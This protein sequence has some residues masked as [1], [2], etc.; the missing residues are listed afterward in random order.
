M[1]DYIVVP[2]KIDI[3]VACPFAYNVN[4]AP[5]AIGTPT[6][7]GESADEIRIRPTI[8]TNPVPGD[9]NGGRAGDPIEEQY[10]G[11]SASVTLELSRFDKD[12]AG[13]L[14]RC[15]GLL[16][17]PGAIPANTIGA[18]M[19]RDNSYRVTFVATVDAT[20][21]RNFYCGIVKQAHILSGG[22]KFE[23][24]QAEISFHRA[25]VGHWLHTN[26][27]PTENILFDALTT[28][29]A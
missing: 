9:R 22:T 16:T 29:I 24:L 18:L 13:A 27:A 5:V 26:L 21:T 14:Q 1:A 8:F 3:Y 2:G 17:T 7:L 15:G 4:A 20:R 11:E 19:R 28:G 25:P 23:M 12:V 6:K 10:L